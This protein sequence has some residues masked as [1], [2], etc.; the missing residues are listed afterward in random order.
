MATNIDVNVND[1]HT[2]DATAIN[3]RRALLILLVY[4][5]L[6]ILTKNCQWQTL[7]VLGAC[8]KAFYAVWGHAPQ[9]I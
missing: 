3:I 8:A 7:E 6:N 1:V 4:E 9:E 5:M 2:S